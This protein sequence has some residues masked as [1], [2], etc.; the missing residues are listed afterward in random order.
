MQ[1]TDEVN[2]NVFDFLIAGLLIFTTAILLN[3]FNTKLHGLPYKNII[4]VVI[5]M[6]FLLVW[7]ELAVGIFGSPL[8]GD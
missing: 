8:A 6:L 7:A 5:I 3:L 2:W 4:L 1:F